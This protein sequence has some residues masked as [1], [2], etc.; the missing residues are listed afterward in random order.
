MHLFKLLAIAAPLIIV[1]A[2]LLGIAMVDDDHD[3]EGAFCQPCAGS[4]EIQ[5]SACGGKGYTG[6]GGLFY[7]CTSCGGSGCN[8]DD[9]IVNGSGW[10]TCP[11]CNGTG[12]Y[13][14]AHTHSYTLTST[15]YGTCSGSVKTYTCSCGDSY[16]SGTKYD[17]H[18]YKSSGT[19]Y[20]TCSGSKTTYTCSRCGDS[21][22]SGTIYNSHSWGPWTTTK[23][24]TCTDSGTQKH[25]C[26]RCSTSA[27]QTISATGH[28]YVSHSAVSATCTKSGNDSY[29]TCSKCST[30]FNSSKTVISSIPT[31]AALGHSWGS[32]TVTKAATCTESGT[33][34]HTCSRCSSSET[35]TV[36]ATGHSWHVSSYDWSSDCT[37]C[38]VRFACSNG[39]HPTSTT[40]DSIASHV[41]D[42][43][44]RWTVTYRVSGTD[45][46]TGVSYSDSQIRYTHFAV[47]KYRDA[48][49]SETLFVSSDA[50]SSSSATPSGSKTFIVRS[51]LSESGRV[52]GAWSDGSSDHSPGS[53]IS[54]PCG[55]VVTLT[56]VWEDVIRY[57][58]VPTA[59]CIVNPSPDY[60]DDGSYTLRSRVLGSSAVLASDGAS[61]ADPAYRDPP[62]ADHV[63]EITDDL[64]FRSNDPAYSIAWTHTAVSGG[65]DN[66]DGA[67][68]LAYQLAYAAAGTEGWTYSV[69]ECSPSWIH[70]ETSIVDHVGHF[71]FTVRPALQQVF[72]DTHGDYWMWFSATSPLGRTTT[73]LLEYSV[74][75]QWAG[76]VIVPEKYSTF[77]L[78]LDYGFGDGANSK[79]FR[80]ICSADAT[81]YRF[82]LVG[83]GISRDGYIFRGWSTTAGASVTDIGEE[84]PLNVG[85]AAVMK[86]SD[87]NGN[88]IYTCTIYAVW[89]EVEKPS[90]SIPD[91]LRDLLGLLQDPYVLAL[92]VL[93]CFLIAV[94]V[95]VRRQG[96]M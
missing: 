17:S 5:C 78:R 4:G 33:Q 84:F 87:E 83:T 44:V 69:Q 51:A 6:S 48:D 85:S 34:K 58:T 10:V 41:E 88:P 57:T 21:Y 26:S 23:A 43:E 82:G 80:Q 76:G 50:V 22:S 92:F 12:D 81:E 71:T 42:S 36:S 49:S 13:Q 35:Q 39:S 79:T 46:T 9:T 2:A 95:R 74:D 91:D 52:F 86:T 27:T 31:K 61:Q 28:S 96:M 3:C 65:V 68:Q 47:L 16:T 1:S 15:S 37:K 67:E 56:A 94:V 72:E 20:G 73:F 32:W 75:V 7:G 45:A 24:A 59:S 55:S 8:L 30:I 93:V 64:T 54:V 25:T 38:T 53:S 66:V 40:V 18:N 11:L 90:P 77:V 62:E 70:W 29:Y 19:T 89:E 60:S 14:E 63:I